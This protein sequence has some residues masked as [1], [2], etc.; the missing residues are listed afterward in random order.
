MNLR[1]TVGDIAVSGGHIYCISDTEVFFTA[2]TEAPA[3]SRMRL[4]RRE[5]SAAWQNHA[6]VITDNRIDKIKFE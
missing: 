5:D 4:R 6:A 1:G 2:A 3:K